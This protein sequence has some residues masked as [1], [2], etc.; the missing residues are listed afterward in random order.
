[1]ERK[2][3]AGSARPQVEEPLIRSAEKE[4]KIPKD[5]ASLMEKIE[6]RVSLSSP[7]TDDQ[8]QVL[9]TSPQIKQA[10]VILPL[11]KTNFITGLRKGVEETVR[12][13]AEWCLRLIK[14][15]PGRILFKPLEEE[16]PR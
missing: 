12:W 13:L 11:T 14:M 10:Q 6:K 16:K 7:V 1:M 9:L 5:V 8:G 15:H 4:V 2:E 3:R